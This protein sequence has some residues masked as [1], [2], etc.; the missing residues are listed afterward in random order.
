M[1]ITKFIKNVKNP[2]KRR[3][4]YSV[5]LNTK[6]YAVSESQKELLGRIIQSM[7]SVDR[8]Y[9][10]I[11]EDGAYVDQPMAIGSGQTISQPSTVARM[12]L[13]SDLKK[14][15]NVLEVGLGSGWAASLIAHLIYP[16]KLVSVERIKPLLEFA[17]ENVKKL[18]KKVSSN[19]SLEFLFGNA[20]NPKNIIWKDKY[21]RLIVAAGGSPSLIKE[22]K[23]VSN[24]K[25]GGMLLFPTQ[26]GNL[27]LWLKKKGKL[28]IEHVEEGYAF[29]PLVGK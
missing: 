19:M 5:H 15:Q 26:V 12:L 17:K 6:D 21:D 23:N 13:L 20:L 24:I 22:L 1:D 16:G 18:P 27:E 9:F 10:L 11:D 3:L 8:K 7:D 2:E 14:G 28:Q 25:D 4:L 29:V